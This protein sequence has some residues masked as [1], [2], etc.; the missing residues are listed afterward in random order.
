MAHVCTGPMKGRGWSMCFSCLASCIRALDSPFVPAV[1][2]NF[3]AAQLLGRDESTKGVAAALTS[4]RPAPTTMY[5]RSSTRSGPGTR[6]AARR[7]RRRA[8]EQAA[9]PHR[10]HTP[11]PPAPRLP[12]CWPAPVREAGPGLWRAHRGNGEATICDCWLVWPR[13]CW[14][15]RPSV[16]PVPNDT[17]LAAR[18]PPPAYCS[19]AHFEKGKG[20]VL[21]ES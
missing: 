21:K 7:A 15:P 2:A 5:P 10:P 9:R 11:R 17:S 1:I 3:C 18:C 19:Q 12:G 8:P 4:A 13:A 16:L 14:P 6:R 20:K